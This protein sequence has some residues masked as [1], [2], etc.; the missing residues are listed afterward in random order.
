MICMDHIMLVDFGST[1]TKLTLVSKSLED[2]VYT[3]CSHTTVRQGVMKGF[4]RAEKKLYVDMKRLGME[5][6]QSVEY[7]VCSS[8]AGGLKM[9]AS[10]LV[11][12][13]TAEAAKLACLGSGAK[14]IQVFSN[15]MTP[16]SFSEVFK[17]E[18]DMILLSGGTDGGNLECILHNTD[19]IAAS[20]HKV[21]VIVAGNNQAELE[22]EERFRAASVP[23]VITDNVMPHFNRISIE[24]ARNAIRKLFMERIIDAKGLGDVRQ[25]LSAEVIPTPLAVLN[26]AYLLSKGTRTIKG[27]GDLVIVDIGGATTDV[28]SICDGKP[29]KPYVVQMGLEEPMVKRTVEGDLGM[30]VSAESLLEAVGHQRL[31]AVSGFDEKTISQNCETRTG[32]TAYMPKNEAEVKFDKSMAC[33]AVELA[34]ERHAGK[35]ETVFSPMGT[36]YYQR[37]KDLS[38]VKHIIGTGGVLVHSAHSKEIL[39]YAIREE[40]EGQCLKPLAS[41]LHLDASYILSCAGLLAKSYPELAM[42]I[43]V[44]HIIQ[45]SEGKI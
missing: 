6:P 26:A 27:W 21:P 44:K 40:G 24:P 32:N 36:L 39:T 41:N 11:R 43:M 19:I 33:C 9:V 28:H 1:Y 2:V 12:E 16:R 4:R 7:M 8:A 15:K 13:L 30:R 38:G 5:I 34:V 10:G 35:I 14:V 18:P 45:V 31:A 42:K 22:I 37:G 20:G 17:K 25:L 23:H 29:S 3:A